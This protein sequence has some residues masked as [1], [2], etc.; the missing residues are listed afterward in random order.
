L[1]QSEVRS[2][3]RPLGLK[4]DHMRRR[5]LLHS[6]EWMQK[7]KLTINLKKT[8]CMLIG[9]PQRLSKCRKLFLNVGDIFI[10]NVKCAKLLGV[11]I[12]E[13]LTWSNETEVLCRKLS[14]KLSLLRRLSNFMSKEALL[15]IYNSVL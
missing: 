8:L 5:D 10:E 6:I 11:Y 1:D 9:T 3:D 13:C 7:N 14:Q 2:G 4:I 12:D 15:K